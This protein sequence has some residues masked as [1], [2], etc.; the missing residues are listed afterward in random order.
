MRKLAEPRTHHGRTRRERGAGLRMFPRV[1]ASRTRLI[2]RR[3]VSTRFAAP[4]TARAPFSERTEG[5]ERTGLT[6][7][8]DATVDCQ[9][10]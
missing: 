10:V 8:F 6:S 1:D 7:V 9:M 4:S 5:E 3:S 2:D